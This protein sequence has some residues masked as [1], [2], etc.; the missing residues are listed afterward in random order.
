M[1][2]DTEVVFLYLLLGT[3]NA[4]A[5][6]GAFYALTFLE[7][8][9]IHNPGDALATEETHQLVFQRNVEYGRA[10]VSLAACTTT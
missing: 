3:L 10:W 6:H 7:A 1:F 5:D 8:Q 9:A 2:T 4:V